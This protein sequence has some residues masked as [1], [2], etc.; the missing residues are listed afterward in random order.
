MN[1]DFKKEGNIYDELLMEVE[2]L[3]FSDY[4][5]SSDLPT[6]DNYTLIQLIKETQGKEKFEINIKLKYYVKG[7][8]TFKIEKFIAAIQKRHTE[9]LKISAS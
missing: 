3:E 9:L 7:L 1:L 8:P 2:S 6:P 5:D 4:L